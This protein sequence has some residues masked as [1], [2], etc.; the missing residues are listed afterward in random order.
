MPVGRRV[1][2]LRR[3]DD[4]LMQTYPAAHHSAFDSA[5]AISFSVM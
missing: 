2:T 3:V 5:A 1:N 4:R